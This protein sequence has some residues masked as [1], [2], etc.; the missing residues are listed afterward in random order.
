MSAR[1]KG[2]LASEPP[3]AATGLNRSIPTDHKLGW[4]HNAHRCGMAPERVAAVEILSHKWSGTLTVRQRRLAAPGTLIGLLRR[5]Q[6]PCIPALVAHSPA[7][8]RDQ[9]VDDRVRS[10]WGPAPRKPDRRFRA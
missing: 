5:L 2:R 3:F 4:L 6:G 1:A 8:M 7:C 9:A 10:T